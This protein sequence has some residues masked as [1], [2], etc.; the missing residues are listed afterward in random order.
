MISQTGLD[1][2]KYLKIINGLPETE[3]DKLMNTILDGLQS[4]QKTIPSMF[5][6]DKMGSKIFQEI[7]TLPEYYIPRLEKPLI[8]DA[9]ADLQDTL[10]DV[11]IIELGCGDCSK[12]SLLLNAIPKENLSGIRYVPVDVSYEAVMETRMIL[13][14]RFA[15]LEIYGILA[16]FNK[17]LDLIPDRKRR[18][19]C[20]FGSTIGNLD[21]EQ[22]IRFCSQVSGIMQADDIL[23]LGADM[24]KAGHI[25][26]NAYND[27][28]NITAR[29]NKNILSV[30]NNLTGTAFRHGSFQHLAFF[31]EE[32]SR[33]EM[34]LEA[35]ESV[36]TVSSFSGKIIKIDK[37]ETIHTENSYKF[38]NSHIQELSDYADLTIK[39]IFT[40]KDNW[41]SLLKLKKGSKT[42]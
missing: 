11:D 40:D 12:I 24:V 25:L 23:L 17:Q 22:R 41:F 16:D 32:Q 42:I 1:Y 6:Y 27:S 20:F 29:F 28:F 34:H 31:N 36:E 30:T 19:F 9:A 5:F 2:H 38:T 15:G 33:I 21:P 14:E 35:V 7:T 39:K 10:K 18:I 37:G 3:K 4:P 13:S 8:R 26:H